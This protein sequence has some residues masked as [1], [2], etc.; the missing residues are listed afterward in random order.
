MKKVLI[1]TYYWPPSGGAGVQRWLKFVKYLRDF[2]WEPVI[3]TPENPEAPSTDES[4]LKDVPDGI[5]I[6][7]NKIWE[8]YTFYKK[9]TGKKSSEKIQ[10][11]FIAEKENK[12]Q[13]LENIAVWLRG[14]LFIPDA[15]KFWIKPSVKLLA[16][17]LKNNP[18]DLI[19]STGPPH[20]AHL[21]ALKLKKRFDIPW[22]ADFRDPWTNIDFYK[23]LKLSKRADRIHHKLE[24]EVLVSA[25]KVVTVS[26][27]WAEELKELGASDVVV[28]TNGFDPD[29]F[30]GFDDSGDLNNTFEICHIGSMNKD[31]NPL[32]LWK[33]L[34]QICTSDSDFESCLK[35][36]FTGQ[37]DFSVK[38]SLK[39][40]NLQN[41]AYF[42]D[43]LPHD[44]VLK[45]AKSATILLL[46]LNNTDNV[47][48]V[49]PG[50]LYE[51]LFLEK[52]ILCIG[53][54]TGD[55]SKII[56]ETNS[57]VVVY[58]TDEKS[59]ISEIKR[60]YNDFRNMTLNNSLKF[61]GIDKYS[62]KV[63]TS[64]I[65]GEMNKIVY[66]KM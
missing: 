5:E 48:G 3:F 37:T 44:E 18:V 61:K 51:Y 24:R 55:S 64:Q 62:R 16:K 20:S 57:G 30:N 34:A 60:L 11:G 17:Y 35:L 9:F 4:L 49:I 6:I 46:A 40:Y 58:F 1:I 21:I 36:T 56:N 10:A 19:V 66:K 47:E 2:G 39:K 53:S 27:H 42:Q 25:D 50:K 26:W 43:Y 14:N 8:P 38:E 23:D 31:R 28:I 22:L 13:L 15:R 32:T 63:I 52:P 65:A 29:D 33:A 45:N 12:F 7:K 41:F 59:M 54:L